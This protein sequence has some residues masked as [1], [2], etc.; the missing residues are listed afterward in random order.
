LGQLAVAALLWPVLQ[1]LR[2]RPELTK[3]L[4]PVG[5]LLVA[6]AGGYWL[7]ERTLLN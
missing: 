6:L 3:K 4:V 2:Q 1:W 5:S 7:V